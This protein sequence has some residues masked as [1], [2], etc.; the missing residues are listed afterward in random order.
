MKGIESS[1]NLSKDFG[2]D[3]QVLYDELFQIMVK[4]QSLCI[5]NSL[6]PLL[7]Y[8]AELLK[9]KKAKL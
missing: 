3:L 2:S 4:C 9:C 7:K 6:E 8:T 5:E 1:F